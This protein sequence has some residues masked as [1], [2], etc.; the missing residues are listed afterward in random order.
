MDENYYSILEVNENAKIDEIKKS[1]RRLSLKYHPDKNPNDSESVKKFHKITEAYETLS[2][3]EKRN[4]YDQMRSNPFVKMFSKGGVNPMDH[5]DPMEE[6]LS[7]IF[8]GGR[9]GPMG[10]GMGFGHPGVHIF[11]NGVP[12]NLGGGNM[13]FPLQKP[14]PI[15]KSLYISMEQVLTGA[16]VPVDIERWIVENGHK[17]FEK[18]MSSSKGMNWLS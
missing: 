11:K 5:F 7:N 14:T 2:N 9:G 3:E 12:V 6:M 1:Y 8:F 13:N 10:M 17:L 16:T 18:E 4:E 15:V